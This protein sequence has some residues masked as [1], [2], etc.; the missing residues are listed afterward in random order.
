MTATEIRQQ[1]QIAD[2]DQWLAV[3]NTAYEANPNVPHFRVVSDF[4]AISAA[5]NSINQTIDALE[6]A[7]LMNDPDYLDWLAQVESGIPMF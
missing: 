7:D 1:L 3:L 4:D 2:L 6:E 5:W